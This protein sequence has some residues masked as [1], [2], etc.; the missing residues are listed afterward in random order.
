MRLGPELAGTTTSRAGSFGGPVGRAI[1]RARGRIIASGVTYTS[2][3][4]LGMAVVTAG[5]PVAVNAQSV[6]GRPVVQ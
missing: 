4:V 6:A 2:F 3:V 5:W 1:R